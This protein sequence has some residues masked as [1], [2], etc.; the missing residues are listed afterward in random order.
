MTDVVGLRFVTEGEKNA[1]AALDAYRKGLARV[2]DIQDK[3][4]GHM[5]RAVQQE[6]RG[7]QHVAGVRKR[8]EQEHLRGIANQIAMMRRSADEQARA[9]ERQA[10]ATERVRQ[11]YEQLRASVD[12]VVAAQQRYVDAEN[13]V[14]AA[15]AQGIITKQQGAATLAAYRSRLTEVDRAALST[16]TATSRLRQ[17]FLAT[18]NSIAILDGPLGGVASRFSAFGILI[19]RTGLLIGGALVSFAAFGAVLNRGIRNFMEWEA[20]SARIN[21][22]LRTTRGEVGLTSSAIE[23]MASS[24]ALNTLESEQSIRAAAARLLTFRDVAGDVFEQVLK[25]ATDMAALGFG[26]VESETTKLAKALEDPA[27]ALTSL[28][29]A[30]IIFTRQQRALIISLVES[31]QRAEAMAKILE[32]V[33]ARTE[34]AAE[35]AASGTLAGAFD[36]IGQAVGRVTRDFASWILTITGAEA[37]I[38]RIANNVAGYAEGPQGLAGQVAAQVNKLAGIRA[39]IQATLTDVSTLTPQERA[40]GRLQGGFVNAQAV[41]RAL[42]ESEAAEARLL[43]LLKDKLRVEEATAKLRQATARVARTTEGLDNIA[44]EVDMQRELLGLTEQEQRVR[45]ALAAEGLLR[46]PQQMAQYLQDYQKALDDA[47]VDQWIITQLLADAAAEQARINTLAADYLNIIERTAAIAQTRARADSLRDE[48]A[49]LAEQ[50]R[51]ISAGVPIAQ[52]RADAEYRL[53]EAK[54]AQQ[55]A[56]ANLE[57]IER[58]H[59]VRQQQGLRLS[60]LLTQD[61]ERRVEAAKQ[62]EEIQKAETD[63]R[64][65]IAALQ[66]EAVL[67]LAIRQIGAES[68]QAEQARLDIELATL[69]SLRSQL[70]AGHRLVAIQESMLRAKYAASR[71][72]PPLADLRKRNED[73]AMLLDYLRQGYDMSAAQ[74]IVQRRQRELELERIE[75]LARAVRTAAQ[76]NAEAERL[77]ELT[78]EAVLEARRLEAAMDAA[79]GAASRISAALGTAIGV[80]RSLV[81][82]TASLT[83]ANFQS[84]IYARN[85]ELGMDQAEAMMRARLEAKRSELTPLLNADD[86]AIREAASGELNRFSD[87]LRRE[88]EA[89]R[90][91]ATELE[92]RKPARAGG[93]AET[94]VQTLEMIV[95]QMSQQIEREQT[96]LELTG[97]K[98]IEQELYYDLVDRTRQAEIN[99]SDAALRAIA[100]E[101][102]ARKQITEELRRQKEAQDFMA[103]SFTSLWMAALE[104]ADAFKQAL[105]GIMQQLAQMLASAAFKSIVGNSSTLGAGA[106]LL[107]ALFNANGNAFS[108]GNVIPFARGGVV[109]SPTMFPMAGNRTGLMGEAGPEAVMPLRRGRDGRLGVAAQ[110]KVDVDVRVHVDDNGNLK[111]QVV[112]ASRDAV[113]QATPGI[114]RAATASVYRINSERRLA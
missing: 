20:Q 101:L 36:T 108:G 23:A 45:K 47:W 35:A 64:D 33:R 54:I 66:R 50:L 52:S 104:G 48:N 67:R 46:T 19:G 76:G 15:I 32:N 111:A 42:R 77:A 81:A 22:I 10:Q 40:A 13:R 70:G 12:P 3:Y 51:L 69:D 43:D 6:M 8:F 63:A 4:V 92:R 112:R 90:R 68:F 11:S 79:A 37:A 31:G 17:Q 72:D 83:I 89:Q 39:A 41:L 93:G 1:I 96:L 114:V 94:E 85:L 21:A 25:S 113:Q 84:E 87:E 7:L 75:A 5:N 98:R 95:A 61:Y 106:S 62:A 88:L 14:N 59:L 80:L 73:Q 26:T 102:A 29:R 28:S 9:A 55:L 103:Q 58:A 34:G 97:Q 86:Y 110:T 53:E 44:A 56:A 27:Q 65:Q 91:I 74:E 49:L 2:S 99:V 100:Q 57:P 60:R 18:A 30:G 107:S 71:L 109:S 38:I 78:L 105:A 24:I 82:E 16:T